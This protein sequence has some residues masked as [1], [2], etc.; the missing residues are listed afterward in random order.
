MLR[1]QLLLMKEYKR[2]LTRDSSG[3]HQFVKKVTL[4]LNIAFPDCM[5]YK[6][7]LKRAT[8]KGLN[9]RRSNERSEIIA[10]GGTW[11]SKIDIKK[12]FVLNPIGKR[13]NK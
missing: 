9:V 6:K 3:S 7:N 11:G 4:F 1:T 8:P 2:Q 5:K 13:Y 12:K 10:P